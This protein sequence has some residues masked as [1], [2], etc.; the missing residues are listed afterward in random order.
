MT[1]YPTHLVVSSSPPTVQIIFFYLPLR[2][3]NIS[4]LLLLFNLAHL[5]PLIVQCNL[6]SLLLLLLAGNAQLLH[7]FLILLP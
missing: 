6:V 2:K 1:V 3:G 5:Y 4:Y 7:K